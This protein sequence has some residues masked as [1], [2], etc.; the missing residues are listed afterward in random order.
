MASIVQTQKLSKEFKR[1][2]GAPVHAVKDANLVIEEGEI[3]SLFGPNGAGK[4]TTISMI[5]GL[6]EPSRGDA[7][8]GGFSITKQPIE[9]KWHLAP[10]GIGLCALVGAWWPLDIVPGLCVRLVISRPLPG[11]WMPSTTSCGIVMA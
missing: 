7:S 1:A 8:T 10:A 6:V 5:S 2:D 11:P 3:F 4:T 9:A